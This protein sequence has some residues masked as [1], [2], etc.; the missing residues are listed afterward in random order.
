MEIKQNIRQYFTHKFII[1]AYQRGYKW[2]VSHKDGKNDAEI[3]VEQI[4]QSFEEGKEEY[5]VQGITVYE[6]DGYI[7]LIDG[8][9]RTTTYFLLLAILFDN[10]ENRQSLL[11]SGNQPRIDYT[12]RAESKSFLNLLALKGYSN[13]NNHSVPDIQDIF[14]FK[15]A[16]K[17][18][19]EIIERNCGQDKE[20][21][22][23]FRDYIL[24]NVFMFIVTIDEKEAPS[25]FTMMNGGKAFMKTD[26]L[27]KADILCKASRSN[28]VRN[29]YE[30]PKNIEETLSLLRKQL[31]FEASQEWDLNNIRSRL[32]RQWDKWLYWWSRKEV[33]M[34]FYT[35]SSPMELLLKTFCRINNITSIEYT[36]QQE[37]VSTVFKQFQNAFLK[38]AKEAKIRF[39]QMRKLQKKFET[40]FTS[41]HSYNYLGLCLSIV[42]KPERIE[43]FCYFIENFN[44]P[45]LLK[46]Y[47]LL[48]LA[49]VTHKEITDN[50]ADI[51]E[52]KVQIMK[53]LLSEKDIYNNPSG[54]EFAF[55]T[56]FM[57]NVFA[58]DRNGTRFKFFYEEDD[59]WIS[60]YNKRSL[61][62]IWP[63][64]KV[65]VTN[66]TGLY[67]SYENENS[68]DMSATQDIIGKID[69]TLFS[70]GVCEH[71]IGN[72]V[73]LH[74][75][76]NS[77]FN[78][79]TPEEK[80]K[81][82]FDL[83]EPLYSRNLLH[84]ISRFAFDNWNLEETPSI[85]KNA[86]DNTIKNIF[87]EYDSIK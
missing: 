49:N 39:E 53:N 77:K 42:S 70:D 15:Q 48:R 9:Q 54:K 56:L 78:A 36:N 19:T 16:L 24:D 43:V 34:F 31:H 67:L 14:Y 85:I 11:M 63:K 3:L 58:S 84:T 1:P 2:G 71:C 29:A 82:Y 44:Q 83:N 23:R 38:N 35:T 32:A 46:R 87:E 86:K 68:N 10:A 59:K 27:V 4:Y 47:T 72:L 65:Y 64:S 80:K 37:D 81:V 55:R 5:F 76:D 33:K 28:M 52:D 26:E 79:K 69:R 50:Q 41:C 13:I 6:K 75:D 25:M 74:K 66:E 61:E 21:L 7:Y 51:I 30:S 22:T 60:Y 62:H 8:Q 40:L 57:L 12:I 73:F 18:M 17:A 45:Q 20:K